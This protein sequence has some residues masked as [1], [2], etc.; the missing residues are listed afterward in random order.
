MRGRG[1][2]TVDGDSDGL[3]QHVSI[4]TLKGWDLAELVELEVLGRDTLSRLGRDKLELKAI[5]LGDREQRSGARV[6]LAD[7]GVSK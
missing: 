2:L 4:G 7:G 5:L 3:A 1:A 6:A